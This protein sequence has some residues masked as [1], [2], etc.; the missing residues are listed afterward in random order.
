MA[1]EWATTPQENTLTHQI[2]KIQAVILLLERK[3]KSPLTIETYR[4]ALLGLA[5]HANLDDTTQTE[6]TIAR[7]KK[8]NPFTHCL[9][10]KEVSNRWKSQLC[11]AYRHYCKYYNIQWEMPIYKHDQRGIQPPSDEKVALLIGASHATMNLKIDISAQTGLRPIEIQGEKGLR[12]KDIHFDQNTITANN[13]KGCNARPPMKITE[14]LNAKLQTYITQKNLKAENLLFPA[15]AET[16][17]DYF[18][19][20]KKTLA[21]RLKDTTIESIRLYDLRHYYITKQLRRT[22][23]AE[24]VRQMVG[25]KNLNT[26]Q[27]YLH[28]MTNTSGEWIV[29]G[30]TDKER[31]KQLLKEDFTYQLTTPDG[32]MMFRKLK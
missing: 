6:I 25:H 18:R 7:Y 30:T 21:T 24:I 27:K 4:K 32:T 11:T 14:Q 12:V 5:Q 31:V 8:T 23:N 9:S 3:G 28:M 22:Q 17:G 16:Y 10:D 2:P 20:F 19:R 1:G 26:T 29:E 15:H 13:T